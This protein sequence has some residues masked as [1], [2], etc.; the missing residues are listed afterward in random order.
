MGLFSRR[1]HKAAMVVHH[2]SESLPDA[3]NQ[4]QRAWQKAQQVVDLS[5]GQKEVDRAIYLLRLA[6]IRYMYLLNLV[7]VS[8]AGK[9][10]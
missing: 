4:A 1:N 8:Y 7:R 3:V 5:L 10:A 2:A 9:E 6:E